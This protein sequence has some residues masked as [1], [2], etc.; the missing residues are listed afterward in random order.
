MSA[1]EKITYNPGYRVTYEGADPSRGYVY[2]R[3]DLTPPA[4]DYVAGLEAA[5]IVYRDSLWREIMGGE[6]CLG[7]PCCVSPKG[8][9]CDCHDKFDRIEKY[10]GDQALAARPASLDTRVVDVLM[11]E[12][13]D[14]VDAACRK[15][16][17]KP[18]HFRAAVRAIIE[19]GQ[20]RG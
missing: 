2:N 20:D 10:A 12:N 14:A 4:A 1:P 18:E 8:E 5:M 13:I 9:G 15:F 7:H 6:G 19:V 16:K 11:V 3:T 17:L